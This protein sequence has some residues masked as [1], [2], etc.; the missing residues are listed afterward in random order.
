[1]DRNLGADGASLA[2]SEILPGL[3]GT[4]VGGVLAILGSA[5]GVHLQH[6]AQVKLTREQGSAEIAG[7]LAALHAEAG[8][9][10]SSFHT[11]VAPQLATVPDGA[12]FEF[13]W[14]ARRDYFTVYDCNAHLLGRVESAEL[15]TLIVTA[16]TAMKGMLDSLE[17]N[18]EACQKLADLQGLG[19]SVD[20]ARSNQVA[21]AERE[22]IEHARGLK[23]SERELAGLFAALMPRLEAAMD[24]T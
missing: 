7:Y 17:Y 24:K 10:W 4:L 2:W 8:V 9:L 12:V 22:L 19:F 13:R 18:G 3:I 1:M 5:W 11:R 16:Y 14:P 21:Q 15:R 20:V 6:K 23:A